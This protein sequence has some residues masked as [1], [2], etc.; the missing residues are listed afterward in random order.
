MMF[1]AKKVSET[2]GVRG[3]PRKHTGFL[4]TED[5]YSVYTIKNN[6]NYLLVRTNLKI[7]E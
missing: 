1:M 3:K 6:V 4:N 7:P 5:K 2:F